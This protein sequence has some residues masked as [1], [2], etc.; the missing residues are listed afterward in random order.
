MSWQTVLK[1]IKKQVEEAI[2]AH[3]QA[4]VCHAAR[5]ALNGNRDAL[6]AI[7]LDDRY[8]LELKEILKISNSYPRYD[9]ETELRKMLRL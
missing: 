6:L 1:A 2:Q 9:A 7:G 3:G 8:R 4:Q 5:M